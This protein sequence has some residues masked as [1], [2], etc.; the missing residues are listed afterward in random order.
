MNINSMFTAISLTPDYLKLQQHTGGSDGAAFNIPFLLQ[1]GRPA[2]G[3][4][5][6]LQ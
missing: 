5:A 2:G 4:A 1:T 3:F 6:I